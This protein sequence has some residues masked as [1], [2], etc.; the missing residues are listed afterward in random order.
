MFKKDSLFDKVVTFA[1][2][3]FLVAFF[4]IFALGDF[5]VMFQNS[6]LMLMLVCLIL[7]VVCLFLKIMI[8][9]KRFRYVVIMLTHSVFIVAVMAFFVMYAIRMIASNDLVIKAMHYGIIV[10]AASGFLSIIFEMM[11]KDFRVL[12]FQKE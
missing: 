11:E 10:I 4:V 9:S 8:L 2:V 12:F 1:I 7:V 6:F 5:G 3:I